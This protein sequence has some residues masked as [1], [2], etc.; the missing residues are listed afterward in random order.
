[1][2]FSQWVVEDRFAA[3]RP[4]WDRVGVEFV[5]DVAPYEEMKLRL[6][7]GSHSMLAYLGYLGGYQYIWQVMR[8]ASYVAL[9]RAMMREEIAPTLALAGKYDLDAYQASI[10]ERFANPALLHGC[11]QI[12]MDGSQKLPQRLL[13]TVRANIAASR[14]IKRLALA[15]A[16]W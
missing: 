1:E 13:G 6:L 11:E 2:P 10:V 9:M 7:N 15:V 5:A 4:A 12:T 3:G 8:D 16:A 14:P